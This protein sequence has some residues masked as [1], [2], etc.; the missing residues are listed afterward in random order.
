MSSEQDLQSIYTSRGLIILSILLGTTVYILWN[1]SSTFRS[2]SL[3]L[4]SEAIHYVHYLYRHSPLFH[5]LGRIFTDSKC[6]KG[7]PVV[8]D[9]EKVSPTTHRVLGLNPGSHTLQGTN[10]YLVGTSSTKILI[11]TGEDV[12]AERYVSFLLDKVFPQTGTKNLSHILLT[13]G[14]GDHQG[15]VQ[16]ILAQLSKRGCNPLPKVYKRLISGGGDFPPRGNFECLHI[17]D[18]DVFTCDGGGV[19][20]RSIYTAGHTDDHV[21][22]IIQEDDALL[23]GDCILGCG[24]TVFD[25]LSEYMKSLQ[26]VRKLM[27]GEPS[28]QPGSQNTPK[29]KL[30]YPG[31]GPV[32]RDAIAKVDEYIGHRQAR[33]DQIVAVL[34]K[35]RKGQCMSSFEIVSAVYPTLAMFVFISAQWNVSHHLNKL[36]EEGKV[37]KK[38][39]DQ[40]R[41][42]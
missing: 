9:F 37:V 12:T 3:G 36:R 25:N 21:S 41:L 42:K 10:T 8:E 28:V 40:W 38:I 29:I 19:T 23:S 5:A 34:S 1:L 35:C 6:P 27:I 13:H 7:L 20:I 26:R 14:H 24:T 18:S 31:H 11:D 30:I 33:E 2:F 4:V 22:F 17:K 15:G 16:L 39:P 32:I